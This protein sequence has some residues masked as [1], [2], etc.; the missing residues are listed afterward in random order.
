MSMVKAGRIK[1][2]AA[3]SQKRSALMPDVPTF[4]ES[5]VQVVYMTNRYSIM[6]VGGTPKPVLKKLH[7]ELTRAIA[8]PDM[9]ERLA[10]AALEPAPNTPEQFRKMLVAELQRLER[11]MKQAGIRPE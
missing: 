8:A 2:L 4:A 9:R 6:S 10:Y 7:A 5:G 1:I 3:A 11:I